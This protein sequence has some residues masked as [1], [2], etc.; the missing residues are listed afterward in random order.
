MAAMVK[1]FKIL[2]LIIVVGSVAAAATSGR[3]KKL[4]PLAD[5]FALAGEEGT[6]SSDP[7]GKW[8]F[9]FDLDLK[10]KAGLVK[11]GTKLEIL[12]SAGLEKIAADAQQH[13]AATYKIWGQATRYRDKNFIFPLYFLPIEKI[14][15]PE[16]SN[17]Q[18]KPAPAINEPD[19]ELVMPDEIIAKLKPRKIIRTIQ[20]KKGLELKQDSILADRTG[21][22][23]TASDGGAAFVL[24]SLG[25]N[26]PEISIRLLPCQALE[27][28]QAKQGGELEPIRFKAAGVVTR[29]K[30]K[31]Y[32]LLHR[33]R[34]I[35]SHGNFGR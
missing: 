21:Y 1:N 28:A 11:A 18:R 25:R 30:N 12:S 19:D 16:P 33:A 3:V 7:N 9:D 26:F 5:G 20:L 15:Q 23:T 2:V 35:Y 4:K 13:T 22:I 6:L 8:F 24:D 10:S 17:T 32:M 27:Y 29:Y 31:N 14:E 34:R